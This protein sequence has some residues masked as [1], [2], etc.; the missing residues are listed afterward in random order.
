MFSIAMRFVSVLSLV[1]TLLIGQ[2]LVTPSNAAA[3][4][5]KV[6]LLKERPNGSVVTADPLAS[7][8]L[9]GTSAIIWGQALVGNTVYAGGSFSNVHPAGTAEGTNLIPRANLLAYDITNGSLEDW[10]PSVNGVVKAVAA[11]PDGKRIYVG[12]TF[13]VANGTDRYNL[14]AFD[15]ATGELVTEFNAAVGGTVVNAIVA[16]NDAVYVGG[17][18]SAG[19]QVPRR[20]LAAFAAS[21][22]A[23]LGWAPTTNLQVDAMVMDPTVAQLIVGGRFDQVNNAPQRGM[24]AL[25]LSTGSTQPWAV[26]NTVLNGLSTGSTSGRAGIYGL[27]ADATGVYGTGWVFSDVNTGNLEGAFAAEAGTGAVRWVADCHGDHYGIYSDGQTVYTTNHVHSCDSIGSIRNG[28]SN[29]A[30]TR[31]ASAMTAAVEGTAIRPESVSNIYKDWSGTPAPAM[32]AWFPEWINGTASSSN[33]AGWSIVGNDDFIAVGGEFLGVNNR[34][35]HGIARFA[36]RPANGPQAGPRLSGSTWVPTAK[37]TRQG[38]MLVSIPAN[39]DRDGKTLTYEFRR[40]GQPQPFATETVDSQYWYLP[41]VSAADTGV[42]TGQSYTYQVRAI[43]SDGNVADSAQVTATATSTTTQPSYAAGVVDDGPLTYW[44]LGNGNTVADTMGTSNGTAV[45]L[46]NTPGPTVGDSNQASTFAGNSNSRVGSSSTFLAPTSLS[47]ELWFKTDTTTGGQLVGLGSAASGN[48]GTYD[49]SVYMSNNGR[50]NFASFF[51]TWRGMATLES[52]NDNVWHHLVVSQGLNGSTLY[53][54]GKV[55]ATD[56]GIRYGRL[57]FNARL[58]VGGDVTGAYPNAPSSQWFRGSIDDV[59]VYP[60]ALTR[61]QTLAHRDLAMGVAAPSPS[62]SSTVDG[63]NAQFNASASTVSS[64][65]TVASYAWD[66]GDGT[67]GTGISPTHRYADAGTYQVTLT[68]TDSA[69]SEGVVTKDVLVHVPP[70]ADFT[71]TET[72]LDA[73]FNSSASSATGGAEITGYSWDFGDGS[74]SSQAT[75]THTF[76]ADGTYAVKLTVTDS[77]GS[78]SSSTI[79]QVTVKALD[80]FAADAFDR[81]VGSGWGT[82]DVGGSW[83]GG[84]GFSTA[85][86]VGLASV[87]ATVTRSTALPVSVRDAIATFS[88][89]VDKSIAGGV[90]QVNYALQRSDAGEYRLKLRYLADGQVTVWLVKRV[91][92]TETLLADGG[93]V[94]GYTQT[95]GARLNVKVEAATTGGGT[96]LRT[97]VWAAGSDEPAGWRATATDSQAALQSAGQVGFSA[98]ANGSVSNGP[99]GFSFD[100]LKVSGKALPHAAPVAGFSHTESGLQSTFDASST[101]TSNN[102]TI[103]DYAWDFGDGSTSSEAA[104][105]HRYSAPGT[106]RATLVVTDSRGARSE[107]V[108]RSVTATHADPTA[109]FVAIADGLGIATD[110]SA[111][112]ATDGATLSYEWSWGDGSATA[113][114]VKASHTYDNPGTYSVRLKVT[115]SVG[116]T[117]TVTKDVDVSPAN[118]RAFDLFGRTLASGWGRAD[119]GGTWTGGAGLSVADGVGRMSVPA[120]VTRSTALPVSIGDS[121]STFTVGVDKPVAGGVAQANFA[122]RKSSAGEYRLKLRYLA[123]GSVTV[124]LV[125][126]VGSTETLL[127]DGRTLAGFAQSAGATLNV[128]VDSATSGG[129]TRL[130]AKVWPTGTTEP[131]AWR[132]TATDSE[133]ALQAPGQIGLSAYANGAVTNGPLT[134]GF[135][136]LGVSVPVASH[137]APTARFTASSTG[138]QASFD[139]TSSTAT[140]N[141]TITNYEWTFGDGSSSTGATPVRDYATEGTYDVTLRVT[142]SQ[143]AVS[144]PVTRSVT[145]AAP[146]ASVS[147]TFNRTVASGWGTA[148]VGGA[149]GAVAGFSVADGAGRVSVPATVT[150]STALPGAIGDSTSTFTVGV[151]KPVAGGV[152]QVNY[153]LRRSSAGE[154]RLKLRYLAN[155]SVTV[156]M[157]KSVNSTETLLSDGGTVAGYTQT[158]EAS[159]N[160]KVDSVTTNGSTRLRAKVWPAGT[161]EPATWRATTTDGQAGLQG[162]GQIGL[163]AYANGAVSNGPLTFS[164]DDLSVN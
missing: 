86:G 143:G 115:D 36:K 101:T 18:F 5:T 157:V 56:P 22:G 140:D 21:S 144:D 67:K 24:A 59:S 34:P 103:T 51:G 160:V 123:D 128:K 163:M 154:Y 133:A 87:P 52:Y 81:T 116:S 96:T 57:N 93:T 20:N 126:S 127:S 17:F 2:A 142:D 84:A 113:S 68:V 98:Y 26:A 153:A 45:G 37:S 136:N 137:E 129:S 146:L 49:R 12:G 110:A 83:T 150:R 31:H 108:S 90:A 120:T 25:N 149:W 100:D 75:P 161:S 72:G 33:Q 62:F 19:N 47:Y 134:F 15:A 7:V 99:L 43:D 106:Y 164:F 32:Y 71:H 105:T 151:D 152:A 102:A 94:G 122:L 125:K 114:G 23:L 1:A 65:R 85:G 95:A 55:A 139:G 3:D 124:W 69:G 46:T 159:L 70:T 119:V 145:V 40:V 13:T 77:F 27:T 14:A 107:L 78:T 121:T 44:R 109:S 112:D 130:R 104:P 80:A 10:A 76:D 141:A 38:A 9:D 28:S 11:S 64:G 111:S 118:L 79:K 41:T 162:A 48:S 29:A 6:P 16:T 117:A 131:A 158:A 138:L 97:K 60:Y 89:G 58:R 53:V 4:L 91:G 147:D 148:D 63:T 50:L 74:T 92:S 88:V 39:R 8:Q 42:T 30:S 61:A 156:W 82:A 132:A 135:D 155:G 66:F 73:S 54:D 35:L